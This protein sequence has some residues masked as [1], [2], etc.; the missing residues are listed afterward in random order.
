M[1]DNRRLELAAEKRGRSTATLGGIDQRIKRMDAT[2]LEIER[3]LRDPVVADGVLAPAYES[4]VCENIRAALRLL[5]FRLADGRQYDFELRNAVRRFQHDYGHRNVDGLFGP[6]TR[7]LLAKTLED[8]LGAEALPFL[9]EVTN[10]AKP[11][12]V[13]LS[14]A[15]AD[16]QA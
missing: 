13:F 11:P 16:S 10:E 3:R 14:Y 8:K 12:L 15:W 9:K 4:V 6:G 1:P 5:G 2:A 7:R